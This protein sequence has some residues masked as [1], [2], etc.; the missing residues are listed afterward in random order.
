LALVALVVVLAMIAIGVAAMASGDEL[1]SRREDVSSPTPRKSTW[2]APIEPFPS[3]GDM[4]VIDPRT[5]DTIRSFELSGLQ[6]DGERSPDGSRIVYQGRGSSGFQIYVMTA[7]GRARQLTHMKGGAAEPTWSPNGKRIAFVSPLWP[8]GSDIYVMRADGTHIKKLADTGSRSR[9]QS[10]DWSPNGERIVFRSHAHGSGT[11]G[12]W[13]VH[14]RDGVLKR[15]AST[16]SFPTWSPHGRWIAFVRSENGPGP[17]LEWDDSDVFVMRADGSRQH[18]VLKSEGPVPR[19]IDLAHRPGSPDEGDGHGQ[20]RL[21]WSPSG[22]FVA[23]IPA[24]TS[25]IKFVNSRTGRVDARLIAVQGHPS[26]W[27]HD[28]MLIAQ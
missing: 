13:L 20:E 17:Q 27:T 1:A 2:F 3:N 4:Y 23:F 6:S 22:R 19:P 16:G 18:R 25:F 28:G 10:P 8:A 5:G 12:I 26:D 24:H 9:D 21:V 15:I 14:T 11:S 7:E